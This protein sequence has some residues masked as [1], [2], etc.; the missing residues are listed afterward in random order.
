MAEFRELNIRDV[1]RYTSR[2]SE[3][4]D[5][6]LPEG[7]EG[8]YEINTDRRGNVTVTRDD[9]FVDIEVPKR[10]K[11]SVPIKDGFYNVPSV[12]EAPARDYVPITKFG[13]SID[14]ASKL[15]SIVFLQGSTGGMQNRIAYIRYWSRKGTEQK[16]ETSSAVQTSSPTSSAPE[17]A[18]EAVNQVQP[19][20][21]DTSK[22]ER[23]LGQ[24]AFTRPGSGIAF[25]LG[26]E[27][28]AIPETP[29]QRSNQ[30]DLPGTPAPVIITPAQPPKP[31]EQPRPISPAIPDPTVREPLPADSGKV[32]NANPGAPSTVTPSIGGAS[33]QSVWQFL[34]NPEEL[35]LDSGPDYNR[36]ETW[37]VSDPANSGQ[38]LSWK[39][40]KNRKLIFG[41][42]LLTGYVIGKRVDSLERGLQQLFMARDGE[43]GNDG[44]PVLEFVWGARVFG[45]CV[46]Q[47]I[48][49]RERAWDAGALVNAEVSF[50]LEQVPEWTINDGFVDIARPGRMPLVNDP[51]LPRSGVGVPAAPGG[52]GETQPPPKKD[53][54]GG[55]GGNPTQTASNPALCSFAK[56]QSGIFQQFLSNSYG[57]NS[58]LRGLS[59]FINARS[60]ENIFEKFYSIKRNFYSGSQEVGNYVDNKLLSTGNTKCVKGSSSNPLEHE[61]RKFV[62]EILSSGGKTFLGIQTQSKNQQAAGYVK[63][64]VEKTLEYLEEW[65]A[66]SPKCEAERVQQRQLESSAEQAKKCEQYKINSPC[67]NFG[68]RATC[69][70]VNGG[71]T[72]TCKRNPSGTGSAFTW[73]I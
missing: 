62:Q 56:T 45:P 20:S 10:G 7:K 26:P 33:S 64:C 44:P 32:Y 9:E 5:A 68:S 52:T 28:Q 61:Y 65:R 3:G 30:F 43:N 36:A 14:V 47:N 12:K 46:I 15:D 18:S 2:S 35:Q 53:Q 13:A 72:V 55:G 4:G 8:F 27:T 23:E 16:A 42:V 37:G 1:E 48:R 22:L 40:N 31:P 24:T 73:Q 49:V 54:E 67:S 25:P 60:T 39:S 34:F 63:S 58:L 51:L 66:T 29:T 41:K 50:E 21:F 59:N 17:K 69:S 19:I 38:P 6:S 11:A 71:A 57:L 70:S